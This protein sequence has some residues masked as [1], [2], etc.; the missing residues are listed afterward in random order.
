MQVQVHLKLSVRTFAF[1]HL[2]IRQ[3]IIF[4]GSLIDIS[5]FKGL[6]VQDEPAVVIL[7]TDIMMWKLNNKA[8][9]V[10]CCDF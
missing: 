6:K 9:F 8:D 4:T 7:Y 1:E 3:Q 2:M 5:H 10:Y